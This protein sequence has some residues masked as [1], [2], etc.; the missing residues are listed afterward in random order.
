MLAVIEDKQRVTVAE[1]P[2]QR[3]PRRNAGHTV[4]VQDPRRLAGHVGSGRDC[5]QIDQPDT[6]VGPNRPPSGDL[7]RQTRLSHTART[8]QR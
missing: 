2:A 5:H 3:F 1:G 7:E 6:A 8:R 4:D